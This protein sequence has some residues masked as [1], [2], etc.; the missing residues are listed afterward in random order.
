MTVLGPSDVED[1]KGEAMATCDM[2]KDCAEAVT[3][4]GSKGYVYCE[5]HAAQRR[6]LSPVA[7]RPLSLPKLFRRGIPAYRHARE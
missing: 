1:Q 7:F 4:I 3:H 6:V 5:K 2:K